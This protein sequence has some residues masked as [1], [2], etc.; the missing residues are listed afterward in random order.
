MSYT[1]KVFGSLNEAKAMS[2]ETSVTANQLA[3]NYGFDKKVASTVLGSLHRS[4]LANRSLEVITPG[5]RRQYK[6]W[7]MPGTK[8]LF[9]TLAAK[10]SHKPAKKQVR[11][12]VNSE[13]YMLCITGPNQFSLT[14]E[15]PSEKL[16]RVIAATNGG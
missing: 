1:Q 7:V 16:C 5:E 2:Q 11:V 8:A 3:E 15:I 10:R 6:Y 14:A 4:K 13:G 12:A 9:R